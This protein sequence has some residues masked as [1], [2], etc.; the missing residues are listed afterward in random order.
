M[1]GPLH[2]LSAA[3]ACVGLVTAGWDR[4]VRSVIKLPAPGAA[5]ATEFG[6]PGVANLIRVRYG[7]KYRPRRRDSTRRA[8]TP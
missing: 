4:W 3:R 5:V 8:S 2:S 1:Q 6:D 7:P